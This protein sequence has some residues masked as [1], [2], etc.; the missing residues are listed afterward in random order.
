M[1]E[2][3]RCASGTY[4]KGIGDALGI[5]YD[6]LPSGSTRFKDGI[7]WLEEISVWS[8]EYEKMH[9]KPHARNKEIA[10]KTIDVLVYNLPGFMKPLGVYFASFLM[11]DRLRD[12]MMYVLL[13][14]LDEHRLT[15]YRI[16]KP[17]MFWSAMFGSMLSLRK[18]YLRY[19][20]LPRPN[21][22]RLDVFTEEPN[23]HGR[24]FVLFYEGAPFYVQPTAWNRWGPVA[25]LKWALGQPLPGD[26]GDK[27][28]PQGYY[29]PD[30]GPKY[31]EGKGRKELDSMKEEIKIQRSGQCPFP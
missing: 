6:V 23:K 26:D 10:D 22:L 2:M 3:E 31:F 18:L 1:T 30:L 7:H 5:S 11:D 17:P 16:E 20:A 19:L 24:N 4:W 9:M 15:I 8:Q 12:A 29:T 13:E 25:W 21:F 14:I 28:Y 27:Y